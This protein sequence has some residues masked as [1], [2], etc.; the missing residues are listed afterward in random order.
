MTPL[1]FLQVAGIFLAGLIVRILAFV[2]VLAVCALPILAAWALWRAFQK[3]RD[4]RIGLVD[5]DGLE[6]AEAHH[7]AAGHT[8]LARGARGTVRVGLD[9]IAGRLLHGPTSVTLPRPG[10]VLAAGL[11]AATVSCGGRSAEI[12]APVTGKVVAINPAVARKPAL[13]EESRYRGGWLF[14]MKP[15][16]AAFLTLPSGKLARAWFKDETA[17]LSHALETELG[18]LA[19]DGGELVVEAPALL[20]EE[21]WQRLVSQF[22]KG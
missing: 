18:L 17:R 1:E 12:P 4:R 3:L 9:E 19:A 11:P 22:L 8:W 2:L 5:V 15:A 6:L 10:T 14:A 13:L 21:K 16:T 7:Y 20:S